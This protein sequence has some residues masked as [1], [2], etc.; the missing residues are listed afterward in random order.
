MAYEVDGMDLPPVTDWVNDWDWLDEQ[1]GANAIEIWNDVREQC[2]M[3][4]TERYG[5]AFMPVTMEAVAQVAQDTEH[6]SS[7]WV[8]VGRT[9]AASPAT[10]LASQHKAQQ[11]ALVD[12]ALTIKG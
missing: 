9:A 2:P 8:N 4:Q 10:G 1:W 12:E 11:I 3:A 6:F 5:R 7:I